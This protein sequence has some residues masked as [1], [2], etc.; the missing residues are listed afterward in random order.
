MIIEHSLENELL[1]LARP[2]LT[3][4]LKNVSWEQSKSS[5]LIFKSTISSAPSSMTRTQ[6]VVNPQ[7]VKY[8][9]LL[10]HYYLY[11]RKHVLTKHLLVRLIERT[12]EKGGE[13]LTL[14]KIYQY[15][16]NNVFQERSACNISATMT[17]WMIMVVMDY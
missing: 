6:Q 17:L 9:E 3:P 8:L 2:D 4:L 12:Q 16:N 13:M 7:Q 10:A 11:K 15:L 5:N 1:E 14:K